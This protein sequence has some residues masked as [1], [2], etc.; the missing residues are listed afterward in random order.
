MD[1]QLR[2]SILKEFR[3]QEDHLKNI[4]KSRK[5][6]SKTKIVSFLADDCLV[7]GARFCFDEDRFNELF[8]I[9]DEENKGIEY[10]KI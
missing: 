3:A 4:A 6:Y 7:V 1:K 2:N 10:I 5:W 8:F 9:S